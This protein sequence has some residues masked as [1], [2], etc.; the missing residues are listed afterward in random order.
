MKIFDPIV[1]R[2]ISGDTWPK[3]SWLFEASPRIG[4]TDEKR[5][6]RYRFAVGLE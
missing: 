3:I 1:D 2:A 4:I 6:F 5:I